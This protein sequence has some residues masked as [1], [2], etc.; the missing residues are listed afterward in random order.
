MDDY[1]R[2]ILEWLEM[3]D[4]QSWCDGEFIQGQCLICGH[5]VVEPHHPAIP[6]YAN[7][8]D[9]LDSVELQVAARGWSG[10]YVTLLQRHPEMATARVTF[11]AEVAKELRHRD[12][13]K[14]WEP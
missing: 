3:I 9:R 13:I 12:R 7:C 1:D 10:L 4:P 5:E 14:L 6:D 11:L 2:L 8:P